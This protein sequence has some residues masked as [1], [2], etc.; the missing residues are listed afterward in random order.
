MDLLFLVFK[1]EDRVILKIWYVIFN[2]KSQN[3]KI[4]SER[5]KNCYVEWSI[6]VFMFEFIFFEGIGMKIFGKFYRI[7][8]F[9]VGWRDQSEDSFGFFLL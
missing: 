1:R 3:I 6:F 5:G 2:I 7:L 4:I 8:Q 9:E